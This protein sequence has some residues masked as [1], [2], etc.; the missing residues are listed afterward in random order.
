MTQ[1]QLVKSYLPH[2]ANAMSCVENAKMSLLIEHLLFYMW[3]SDRLTPATALAYAVE[4]GVQ[5][6]ENKAIGDARRVGKMNNADEVAAKV[7][8][9]M[10]AERIRM[11]VG[12]IMGGGEGQAGGGAGGVWD[13][14]SGLE[15]SSQLSDVTGTPSVDEDGEDLAVTPT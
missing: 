7:V 14:E 11:V 6:R 13:V 9:E 5:A 15:S 4:K 1:E 10:S 12:M 2:P 8:L 3:T